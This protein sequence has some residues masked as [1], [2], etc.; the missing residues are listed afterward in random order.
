MPGFFEENIVASQLESS[1]TIAYNN[2][3]QF[4]YPVKIPITDFFQKIKPYLE[5]RHISF[6]TVNC[7]RV[8]LLSNG[9]RYDDFKMGKIDIH[10]RQGKLQLLKLMNIE[11]EKTTLKFK[12]VFK[13]LVRFI[14]ACKF[15]RNET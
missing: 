6:G 11:P 1:G 7:C 10:I 3:M 14:D 5:L 2:L 13:T 4:G 9:F 15:L 12:K 8:I